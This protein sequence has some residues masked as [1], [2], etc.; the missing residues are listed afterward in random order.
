MKKVTALLLSCILLFGVFTGAAEEEKKTPEIIS[1]D[2]DLRFHL[3]ADTFPFRDRKL[4]QGYEELLDVLEVK[5]N[6]SYCPA[7]DCLDLNFR[8]IP[9]SDPDAALEFRI[10][11]WVANWLNVSSPLLG[12][13]AVCFRPKETLYFSVRAWDFFQVPLF[14]F[15]ILFP[16]ILSNAWVEMSE[17]WE[18]VIA[19]EMEG[20]TL[21]V[22]QMQ[23]I[24][25]VLRTKLNEHEY[26]TS[27]IDAAIKSAQAGDLI[28]G[29]IQKLPDLLLHAADGE[30]LTL[31]SE[32]TENEK[33]IR[34]VNHRGETIY[35]S[36]RDERVS[37]ER[38]TLPGSSSD[39]MPAYSFRQEKTEE[40]TACQLDVSW[41]RVSADE[42]LPETFLRIKANA[43]HLPDAFPENPEFSGEAQVEGLL[44]PNFH[45]LIGCA[46][47]ADGSVALTL[48]DPE[49]AEAE[50]VFRLTGTFTPADYGKPLEY[51]IGDIITD[52]NLFALTDQ[53]LG[54]LRSS[55]VPA[56]T[57]LLPDFMYAIPT[58]GVQSILD[59]LESY[60]LL[61]I[62]LQ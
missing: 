54:E 25:E 2:F 36:H 32:E 21:T 59:T 6:Y 35:E 7:T 30:N 38:L 42:T 60:G 33:N 48:R 52:Y 56:L 58:R 51:M 9:V 61:Q 19:E 10:F 26:V 29:E 27:L 14:H 23:E 15:A 28:Y 3:E 17:V 40:G 55:M 41:D 46:K 39:Y 22:G 18:K 50:P 57:E 44:L 53:T 49:K 8:L 4:M 1:Y 34:Y 45:Y 12:D 5:G 13:K 62:T 37:E 24:T 11:G 16:D 43:D 31:E 20:N 47:E